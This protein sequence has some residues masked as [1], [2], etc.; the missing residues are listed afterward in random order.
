MGAIAPTAKKLWGDAPSLPRRNFVVIFSNSKVS[1]FLH[2]GVSFNRYAVVDSR[3]EYSTRNT[4]DYHKSNYSSRIVFP[5]YLLIMVKPEIAQFDP[6]T[7]K[8]PP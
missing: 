4:L 1:R 3:N 6:P 2:I 7:P 8:T 5:T